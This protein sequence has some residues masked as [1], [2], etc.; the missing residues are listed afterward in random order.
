VGEELLSGADMTQRQLYHNYP[1]Q[2]WY[3]LTKSGRLGHTAQPA[4]S[5]MG[6][7]VSLLS[8]TVGPDLFHVAVLMSA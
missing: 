7:R 3:Q 1:P 6:R 8:D 2:Q 4:G 5:S